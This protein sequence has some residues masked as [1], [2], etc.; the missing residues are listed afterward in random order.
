[1]HIYSVRLCVRKVCRLSGECTALEPDSQYGEIPG[2]LMN[3]SRRVPGPQRSTRL[4]GLPEPAQAQ[5]ELPRMGGGGAC[6]P[7][8]PCGGPSSSAGGEP[9][10]REPPR[11]HLPAPSPVPA[12]RAAGFLLPPASGASTWSALLCFPPRPQ[13]LTSVLA[14]GL[15]VAVS[16]GQSCCEGD[17][18]TPR[19]FTAS[20][21]KKLHV[22][23]PGHPRTPAS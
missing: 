1:M 8:W 10:G 20:T 21:D 18:R 12:P 5:T 15:G 11:E 23:S 4:A 22:A 13:P 6:R 17:H 14:R 19:A 16:I 7:L 3:T 2:R 9:A